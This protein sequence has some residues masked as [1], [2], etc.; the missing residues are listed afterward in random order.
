MRSEDEDDTQM[1]KRVFVK[2]GVLVGFGFDGTRY[3]VM[4]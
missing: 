1:R 2:H 3:S 4:R